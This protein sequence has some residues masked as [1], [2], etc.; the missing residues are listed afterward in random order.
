MFLSWAYDFPQNVENALENDY[1]E[2]PHLYRNETLKQVA[3]LLLIAPDSSPEQVL[4][5]IA[6]TQP[7]MR[8]ALN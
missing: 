6:G 4:S 5:L 8:Q 2:H 3:A 7:D 1:A